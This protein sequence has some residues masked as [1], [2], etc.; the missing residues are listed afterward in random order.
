MSPWEDVEAGTYQDLVEHY[1]SMNKSGILETTMLSKNI[2]AIS[3]KAMD[4]VAQDTHMGKVELIPFSPKSHTGPVAKDKHK[5][6]NENK[7]LVVDSLTGSGVKYIVVQAKV[8]GGDIHIQVRGHFVPEF[9]ESVRRQY[10]ASYNTTMSDEMKKA[11]ELIIANV[12][13]GYRA[14]SLQSPDSAGS[15]KYVL[16]QVA[17]RKIEQPGKLFPETYV[18]YQLFCPE[19]ENKN[20]GYGVSYK[21]MSMKAEEELVLMRYYQEYEK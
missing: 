4:K 6:G 1:K 7:L 10:G 13:P 19:F 11:I 20:T 15:S 8:D 16:M 12:T 5:P 21:S 18:H 14:Y 9:P 17:L 2:L 3:T